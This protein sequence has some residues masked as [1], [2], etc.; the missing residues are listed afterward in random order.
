MGMHVEGCQPRGAAARPRVGRLSLL[1]ALAAW[2]CLSGM[3]A[4]ATTY[5]VDSLRG[6]DA[7][8]GTR[9]ARPWK[10]LE[11]VGR[12]E[13]Q[14][15]DRILLRSGCVWT[16]E[17]LWPKGSGRPGKPIQI[18]RYGQG[19]LPLLSGNGEVGDVVYLYNQ[20]YWEI[21][22]LEITNFREGDDP[23]D[24]GNVMAY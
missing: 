18:G 4:S 17:Q 24:S 14:P 21:G 19:T 16:A 7:N 2:V 5:Y 12:A 6:D 9:E 1:G 23:M 8:R 10:T 22:E 11:R 15:G 20:E 13:F 3:L